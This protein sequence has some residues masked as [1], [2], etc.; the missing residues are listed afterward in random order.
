MAIAGL[1]VLLVAVAGPPVWAYDTDSPYAVVGFV[2]SVTRWNAIRDA[3]IGWVR[4][5][6]NWDLVEQPQKGTF[7]WILQ[8]DMV[9]QANARGLHIYAGL[10]YTPTWASAGGHSYDVPNNFQDWYDYVFTCVNRYKAS[11][12]Y[13]EV[14]NEPNLSMF[15]AGTRSQYINNILKMASD[16]AHAADPDCMI[17]APEC[18]DQNFIRDALQLAGNKVDIISLHKYGS[19]GGSP[20]TP[21]NRIAGIDSLHNYIVS[22]GYSGK[23]IWVTESGWASDDPGMTEQLEGDYL[24]GMLAGMSSRPWWKTFFWY[25]IWEGPPGTGQA[26]LL[27]QNETP[28]PAWYSQRDYALAHPAPQMVS[29]NLSTT[30]IVNGIN[31]VTVGD[32]NTTPATIANRGCR[33]N[34]NPAANDHYIYFNV[35]D[36]FAYQGNRPSVT[37]TFDYHDGGT[38]V[39]TLEYDSLSNGAYQNAGSVALAGKDTWKQYTFN[40]TDAY[41]GNRQNGGADFRIYPNLGTTFYL[42]VVQVDAPPIALPG[43]ASNPNPAAATTNVSITS[44]LS[45]TAG[46]NTTSHGVYFGMTSPGTFQGNQAGTTYNPGTLAQGTTYFWRIDENN[47]GGTTTGA[48]WSFTTLLLPGQ[49]SDPRPPSETTGLGTTVSLNWTT[50]SNTTSHDVYFGT[51][52]P[53]T[54]QGNQAGTGFNPPTLSPGT[55]YYWRI[56]ENNA[57]GT[58]TGA[59]WSFKTASVPRADFDADGDVDQSDFAHLQNCFNGSGKPV[60][61]GCEDADLNVDGSVDTADFTAFL[62]CMGGA[63]HSPGC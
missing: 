29:V 4:C 49:A 18:G 26:G 5:P 15:W 11:I 13:W 12:K 32:G 45:W 34:T 40:L 63:D 3:G 35:V 2:P 52:S 22:L 55:K 7:N 9:A 46:S 59:L 31:L 16:A 33:R 58:T 17:F 36:G 54:F 23:A 62:P 37:V 50:G 24:V 44:T 14:W 41:F 48:V 1:A 21:A 30:D 42:D 56:D 8:D 25:Q 57:D 38:G 43:Q 6:F 61:L 47:P 53:G 60:P 28:K 10:G 19:G 39:V 51:V 27:Y 20:D